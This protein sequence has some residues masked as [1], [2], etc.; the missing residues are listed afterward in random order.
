ME[1]FLWLGFTKVKL[2]NYSNTANITHKSH[3]SLYENLYGIK[4]RLKI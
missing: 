3:D 2:A 4:K 1:E